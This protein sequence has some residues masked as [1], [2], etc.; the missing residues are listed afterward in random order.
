MVVINY[1]AKR[2]TTFITCCVMEKN[3]RLD[4]NRN[5]SMYLG[6]YG[7]WMVILLNFKLPLKNLCK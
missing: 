6:T 4:G 5:V 7:A 3:K 1:L 2:L